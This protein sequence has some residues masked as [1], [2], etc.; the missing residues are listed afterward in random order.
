MTASW[1]AIWSV[2][3]SNPPTLVVRSIG[4]NPICR[5]WPAGMLRSDGVDRQVAAGAVVLLPGG[6]A[7]A[8]PFLEGPEPGAI[9]CL[10]LLR[11]ELVLVSLRRPAERYPPGNDAFP[12][13]FGEGIRMGQ[14]ARKPPQIGLWVHRLAGLVQHEIVE[15][16]V[17]RR[18]FVQE[19]TELAV[20]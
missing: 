9:A 20:V 5:L 2:H 15:A 19:Q 11:Q 10:Q 13:P 3:V 7:A 16:D 17:R 8:L 18:G 14:G 4:P 12:L 1:A 6:S